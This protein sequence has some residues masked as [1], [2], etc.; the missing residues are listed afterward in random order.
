MQGAV[1]TS[2]KKVFS[3]LK[4]NSTHPAEASIKTLEEIGKLLNLN[5]SRRIK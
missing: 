3:H 4:K 1:S 5:Y 2:V